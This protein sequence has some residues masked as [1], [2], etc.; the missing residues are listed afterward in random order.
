MPALLAEEGLLDPS[1]PSAELCELLLEELGGPLLGELGGLLLGELSELLGGLELGL[2]GELGLDGELEL[3]VGGVGGCGVVGLLALG[4][5]L[6]IRQAQ[7]IP[8]NRSSTVVC[9]LLP[10]ACVICP[11]YILGGHRL[12]IFETRSKAGF[13]QFPHKPVAAGLV[14]HFGPIV[15][16]FRLCLGAFRLGYLEALQVNNAPAITDTE[17]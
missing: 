14:V 4:Q 11:N 10:V 7:A 12:T 13:A 15:N 1:A 2:E 3:G 5:P 16:R 6:S 8:A 9:R 17:F